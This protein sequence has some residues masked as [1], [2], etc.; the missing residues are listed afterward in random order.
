MQPFI[1]DKLDRLAE[2][3]QWQ[4]ILTMLAA[5][6]LK[7]NLD[8]ESL[9]DKQW[10]DM[11]LV[12]LQFAGPVILVVQ[13][14]ITGGVKGILKANVGVIGAI[15]NIRESMGVIRKEANE[16]NESMSSS[17]EETR[18]RESSLDVFSGFR[19]RL[20]RAFSK[21]MIKEDKYGS[22]SGVEMGEIYKEKDEEEGFEMENPNIGKTDGGGTKSPFHQGG[23]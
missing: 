11:M 10:F 19:N 2:C 12:A 17:G 16:L 22:G 8:G 23:V 20:K 7:V 5:L 18:G 4:M 1:D 9:E 14:Y 21:E 6:A 13:Q 15:F 3:L